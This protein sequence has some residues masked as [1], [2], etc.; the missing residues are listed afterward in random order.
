M[1]TGEAEDRANVQGTGLCVRHERL[2]ADYKR[3]KQS[4][5]DHQRE[6]PSGSART[7]EPSEQ[8]ANLKEVRY[9]GLPAELPARTI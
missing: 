7:N 3:L 2:R 5:T 6:D 9:S 1:E 8:D 4:E